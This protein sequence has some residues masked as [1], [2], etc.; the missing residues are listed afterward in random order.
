MIEPVVSQR[1]PLLRQRRAHVSLCVGR[2]GER[3][4][5]EADGGRNTPIPD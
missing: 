4:G 3:E 1:I 5:L 2:F